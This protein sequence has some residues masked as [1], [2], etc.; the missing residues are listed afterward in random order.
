MNGTSVKEGA[1]ET[2]TQFYI[3]YPVYR[4]SDWIPLP[5]NREELDFVSHD[6]LDSSD[7]LNICTSVVGLIGNSMTL[8]IIILR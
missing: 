4:S 7:I 5:E 8:L 1:S 2:V 3:S 6:P